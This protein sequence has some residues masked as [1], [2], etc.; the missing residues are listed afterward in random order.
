MEPIHVLA[1]V[2]SFYD[3]VLIDMLWKWQ[4]HQDT[5]HL[6]VTVQF[7]N[8]GQDLILGDSNRVIKTERSNAH[9]LT[10]LLLHSDICLRI[11]SSSHENDCE[12]GWRAKRGNAFLQFASDDGSDCFAVDDVG[13]HCHVGIFGFVVVANAARRRLSYLFVVQ[14]VGV[15]VGG[16][17]KCGGWWN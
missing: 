9:F 6:I 13:G 4:L 16:N 5:M 17:N 7:L 15:D 1:R 3:I 2:N 8:L 14:V 11:P 12:A 10:C